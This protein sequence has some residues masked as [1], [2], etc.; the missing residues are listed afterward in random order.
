MVNVLEEFSPCILKIMK[1][2]LGL[3]VFKTKALSSRDATRLSTLPKTSALAHKINCDANPQLQV[4]INTTT[5]NPL[6]MS[7]MKVKTG[8]LWS[9]NKDEL[10]KQLDEWKT[11]LGSIAGSKDCWGCRIQAY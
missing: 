11:E 6:T 4:D 2:V 10:M 8:Q 1:L 7:T 3:S 9:K 5:S